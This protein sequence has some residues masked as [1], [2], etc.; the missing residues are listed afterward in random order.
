MSVLSDRYIN[1]MVSG[2]TELCIAIERQ[3]GLFGYPPEIV[4]IGLRAIDEGRDPDAAIGAYI[5]GEVP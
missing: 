5:D 1:A 2:N 4:S 3:T